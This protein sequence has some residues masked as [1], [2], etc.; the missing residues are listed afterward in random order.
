MSLT[1]DRTKWFKERK[2][3]IFVHYLDFLQN[4]ENIANNS[5]YQKTSWDECV[6]DFDVEL[7]AKQIHNIGA[8]YV[9]FTLCQADKY[10]CAP[11]VT[12][13]E[14]SGYKPGEACS[15]RDL[16]MELVD[17]LEKY[18]IGLMLY[19]TGDGPRCDRQACKAFGA[20]DENKLDVD[21]DF[22]S[23]WA[24]VMKEYS[25]RYG[26]KVHGWWIDGCFDYIGYN[27]ELLKL[28]RDAALAGNED[29]VIAFNNGIVR[30]DFSEPEIAAIA[31][32][33]DRY[34]KKLDLVDKAARNG[35]AAARRAL[36]ASDTPPKYRYSKYED[37]T[38]GESSYFK[39][40]P[41]DGP[42]DGCLWHALSFLGLGIN[43][44]L[45]SVRSGWAMPGSAYSGNE[46]REYVNNVNS[47]G[48]VVSIDV[49]VRRD[50]SMDKAQLE[51]LK[52]INGE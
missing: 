29:A 27:D 39:E 16:P 1:T 2:W 18:G 11:N 25:L 31:A 3:G 26:K 37:Y 43:M 32:G 30:M 22:V 40:I 17:A 38:A 33:A 14:I 41:T 10:L 12:F 9:F 47:R 15:V 49:F 6:K 44:P 45:W 42:V 24:A 34:M 23:K 28:Y 13:D 4:G 5:K 46:L 19:F 36:I 7:F 35:N 51:V 20:L 21:Y 52:K 8:G 48:G 50:G